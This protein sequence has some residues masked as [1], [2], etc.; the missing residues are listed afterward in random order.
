MASAA[1]RSKRPIVEQEPR[2]TIYVRNYA[3]KAIMLILPT[4]IGM[5]E[6]REKI[7]RK[8]KVPQEDQALFLHGT[9]VPTDIE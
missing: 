1:T 4:R 7:Q 3:K 8:M 5:R 9:L 6:L 2:A